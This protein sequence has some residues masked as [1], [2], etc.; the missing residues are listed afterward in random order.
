VP[1]A[2]HE[3]DQCCQGIS[4]DSGSDESR[5]WSDLPHAMLHAIAV[6]KICSTSTE[7]EIFAKV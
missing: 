7:V 6:G 1:E 3:Y 2:T 5:F 4:E